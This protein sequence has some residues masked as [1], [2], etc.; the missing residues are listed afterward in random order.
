[1]CS[2]KEVEIPLTVPFSPGGHPS[3]KV[4]LAFILCRFSLRASTILGFQTPLCGLNQII[5]LV[6]QSFDFR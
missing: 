5:E 3:C 6:A 2:G 1:M 4:V